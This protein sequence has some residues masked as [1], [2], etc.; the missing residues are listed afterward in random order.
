MD[1]A[2]RALAV[3]GDMTKASDDTTA[4]AQGS[5]ASVSD[6]PPLDRTRGD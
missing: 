5:F 6:Q 4:K 3:R 1:D 2:T